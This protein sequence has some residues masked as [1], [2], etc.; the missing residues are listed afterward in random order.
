MQKMCVK[1]CVKMVKIVS[2]RNAPKGVNPLGRIVLLILDNFLFMI[3]NIFR[4]ETIEIGRRLALF[5]KGV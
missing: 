3:Y 1:C 2:K 4:G 5:K